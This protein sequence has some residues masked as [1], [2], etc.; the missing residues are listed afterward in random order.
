MCA[1]DDGDAPGKGR[2]LEGFIRGNPPSGQG[3][4]GEKGAENGAAQ[5]GAENAPKRQPF[6]F[7]RP[8][9]ENEER[10][11]VARRLWKQVFG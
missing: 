8:N 9:P 4:K 6:G 1:K 10:D 2:S 5:E 7:Y 3:E 11:R